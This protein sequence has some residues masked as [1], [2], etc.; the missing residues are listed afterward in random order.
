M[1]QREEYDQTQLASVLPK[2]YSHSSRVNSDASAHSTGDIYGAESQWS[3]KLSKTSFQPSFASNRAP[4]ETKR[5]RDRSGDNQENENTPEII[6]AGPEV[7]SVTMVVSS[8]YQKHSNDADNVD[9]TMDGFGW[10]TNAQDHTEKLNATTAVTNSPTTVPQN[11]VQSDKETLPESRT[12]SNNENF[13]E[14]M[15]DGAR[16]TKPGSPTGRKVKYSIK[17]SIK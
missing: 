9:T 17:Y 6:T 1:S 7:P 2:K 15:G 4:G 3:T 10:K 12:S 11:Q 14:Q 5:G 13:K 8:D 16:V